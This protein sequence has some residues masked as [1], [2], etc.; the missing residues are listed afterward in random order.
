MQPHNRKSAYRV[1]YFGM[2]T[3]AAFLLGYVE[4][5]IPFSLGIYGVKLGLANL[6][7]LIALYRMGGRE[8]VMV[9]LLR[10]L[11]TGFT[12]G[13]LSMMLYSFAGGMLS[14][15]VMILAQRYT[16]LSITGVS[17]LGGI[18]HNIGQLFV[19]VFV[20]QSVSLLFYGIVLL[21]AGTFTGLVI[22]LVA[23]QVLRHLPES[24][25]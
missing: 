24:M 8:A 21:A 13:N 25:K 18:F 11:L 7:V 10:V 9:S 6:A 22:G 14:C 19:A 12:F 5:L 3:A 2:L 15:I 1:A 23:D 20:L 4:S 17:I 16:R